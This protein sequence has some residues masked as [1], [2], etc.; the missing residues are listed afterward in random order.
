[1]EQFTGWESIMGLQFENLVINNYRDILPFLHLDK[2]L[3]LSASPY[4]RIPSAKSRKKG[5]QIDLLLQTR[6][7]VCLVE[8]KRQIQIGREVIDEMREKVRRF[9]PPRGVSVRT[10]LIYDG[11]LVPS[12]EADGYFDALVPVRRLLGI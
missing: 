5:V 9:S 4:R 7:S 10:A 12:V 1:M 2:T 3:L 8:I 6:L 11:E